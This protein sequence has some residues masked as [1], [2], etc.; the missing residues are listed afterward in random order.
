M[1]TKDDNVFLPPTPCIG[2]EMAVVLARARGQNF[3]RVSNLIRLGTLQVS[4]RNVTPVGVCVES[5]SF[6]EKAS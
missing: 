3:L 6:P 1:Y 4:A 5:Q 2:R